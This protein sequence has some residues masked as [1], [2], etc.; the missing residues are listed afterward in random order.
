MVKAVAVKSSTSVHEIVRELV[1]IKSTDI[2]KGSTEKDDSQVGF[3]YT[4]V[5]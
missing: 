5:K 3:Y 4:E 1:E 2:D